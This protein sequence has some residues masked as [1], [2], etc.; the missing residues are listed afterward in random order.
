MA[1]EIERKFLVI[2]DGWRSLG[3]GTPYRQG[4]IAAGIGRT[5]RVRI[6]GNQAF[7]TIKGP[8]IGRSRSEFEYPI[9][10]DDARQML[11]SLCERPL[12]E[13][14]R[15][16]I[17]WEGL[18]WEVDEFEGEN[19]GLVMAEVELTHEKQSIRF[20]EWV[21]KEVSHDPRYYNS[22]LMKHPFTRW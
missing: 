13:K 11:H 12:I 10:L 9:P 1:I 3:V 2:G 4:Y 8:T 16:K 15:Y 6:A 20:P 5:V 17:P 21:G 22:N 19:K 14:T 7:L 18:T